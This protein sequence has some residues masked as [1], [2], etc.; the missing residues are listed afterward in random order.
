MLRRIA[1]GFALTL[2][3]S[4][5]FFPISFTFLPTSI[6]SK[7]LVAVFG[8]L[9]FVLHSIRS[10]GMRFSEPTVFSFL[11]AAVFSVWCL[12]CVT[13][14]NTYDTIYATYLIS[15]ITWLAGAYG[16]YAAL[17]LFYEKV[18]LEILVRFL[19]LVGVYA[20][21]ELLEGESFPG[22]DASV[23]IRHEVV[24]DVVLHHVVVAHVQGFV[25]HFVQLGRVAGHAPHVGLGQAVE[26]EDERHQQ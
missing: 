26:E 21:G 23:A 10:R 17:S 24:L 6:N 2:I 14:S 13:E 15:F 11:M 19:A 12:F 8:I 16:V 1:I 4:A 9:S 5:Y 22:Q 3:T 25:H 7:M 18:D 20:F